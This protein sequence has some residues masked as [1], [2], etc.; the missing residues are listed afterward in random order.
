MSKNITRRQFVSTVAAGGALVSSLPNALAVKN[1]RE[2]NFSFLLLG[3]THFD[4]LEHHDFEWMRE[5]YAKVITQVK[6]Y[7]NHTE[8]KLP[9]LLA[10]AKKR[11]SKANPP[12]KFALHVGDLVQ[13]VCGNKQLAVQHCSEGW[14]YFKKA[15]LGV[16]LIM[17]KGNHD[18][19]GP[20]AREA[21]QEV[22]LPKAAKELGVEKLE[23]TSYFFKQGEN[24][25]AVFDAY[26]QTAIDWLEKVVQENQFRRLFVLVHMPVVPYNAR[27]NWRVYHHPRQA[28]R[29][30]RLIDLLGKHQAIVLCGHLHKYSLLVRRCRTGQFAQLAISSVMKDTIKNRQPTLNSVAD[31]STKLT[32]MEP[33]FSPD[34]LDA[35]QHILTNEKPFIKHF[36]YAHN[37]G[38][39]ILSVTSKDVQVE[40]YSDTKGSLPWKTISLSKWLT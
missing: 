34:T 29:R 3:D 19:T 38:F 13:G 27:S 16:P 31:Y 18:I 25:F 40:I 28:E 14:D 22:L 21:Y 4:R 15:N 17:T 37:S 23:R 9:Q 8:E 32:N 5:H 39:A 36:E 26:D 10:A 1:D 11:L 35:R 33:G 7:S 12:K 30:Q 20:G 24:L 2:E 6:S